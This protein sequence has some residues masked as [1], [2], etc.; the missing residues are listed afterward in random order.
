MKQSGVIISEHLNK[1]LGDFPLATKAKQ[2]SDELY[3]R[4]LGQ[5][6][7]AAEPKSPDIS[8]SP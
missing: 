3:T 8:A 5:Q 6:S 1:L 4:T 2:M 7:F